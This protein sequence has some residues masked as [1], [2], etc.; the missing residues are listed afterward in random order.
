MGKSSNKFKY[1]RL[2][3]RDPWPQCRRSPAS[4]FKATGMWGLAMMFVIFPSGTHV[5][6][7]TVESNQSLRGKTNAQYQEL[8]WLSVLG[9]LGFLASMGVSTQEVVCSLSHIVHVPWAGMLCSMQ[10]WYPGHIYIYI[11][12]YLSFYLSSYLS[13]YLSIYL[14]IYI[15]IDWLISI[16]T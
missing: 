8:L 3:G 10:D 16:C 15:L 4:I 1:A 13:I 7:W 11:C 6:A 12:A 2:C 14:N 9:H 5:K